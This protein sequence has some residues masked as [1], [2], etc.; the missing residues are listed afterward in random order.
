MIPDSSDRSYA[1]LVRLDGRVAVVTGGALGIGRAV[2]RRLAEAGATVVAADVDEKA[3]AETAELLSSQTGGAVT[4]AHVDVRD[5]GTVDALADGVAAAHGR[6]DIWVNNAGIY[7]NNPVFELTDADWDRV[8]EI[9]V[10]G[11]FAGA[12][13]AARHMVE[14]GAGGVILN[15]SSI[16]GYR[17]FGPGL[18]HYTTTKHAVRGLTRALA[19]ELGPHDIRVLS[20]APTMVLTEGV[21][22][23]RVV[24]GDSEFGAAMDALAAAH[25]AGRVGVPDDIARVAV[26]C[27]SD[28]SSMMTGS[29]VV[30]D[31]GYLAL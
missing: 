29:T 3:A 26:F 17:A 8:L 2:C 31:G 22:E 11:S 23:L 4:A 6:I 16:N 15:V 30:V 24:M 9:N 10:R 21:Q 20:I 13:A 1:D 5:S 7:P 19:V 12:R 25:A 14:R 27:A 28:L 18:A